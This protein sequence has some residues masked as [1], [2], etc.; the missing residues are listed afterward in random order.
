MPVVQ[1][2]YPFIHIFRHLLWI[3]C[4][5]HD[6]TSFKI[7]IQHITLKF[8]NL[9]VYV[10]SYHADNPHLVAGCHYYQFYNIQYLQNWFACN[11]VVDLFTFWTL[12][13]SGDVR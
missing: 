9:K 3:S 1:F 4:P 6:Q 13:V 2:W 10:L 8:K 7:Y 11:L 5:W 12:S